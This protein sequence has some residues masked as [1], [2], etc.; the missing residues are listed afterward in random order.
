MKRVLASSH[1][2]GP[3]LRVFVRQ[4]FTRTGERERAVIQGVVDLLHELDGQPHR[5]QLVTGD[6]AESSRTFRTRFELDTGL[7]F[8]PQN[9]RARR[10]ALLN[11]ADAMVVIRTG[12][13]ESGAFEVAYNIFGGSRAPVFLAIWKNAP[14]ETTLL[15][16]LDE[17]VPI[18]YVTFADPLELR[19]SLLEF[20][21]GGVGAPTNT[22]VAGVRDAIAGDFG[23]ADRWPID[24]RWSTGDYRYGFALKGLLLEPRADEGGESG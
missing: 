14:I 20:F 6:Q 5:L 7:P 15:R 2:P 1:V 18:R 19:A 9:F 13:S 16:E 10:L 22:G 12:L 24:T 23:E 3:P 8:T 11:R 17:L 4:P 21:D